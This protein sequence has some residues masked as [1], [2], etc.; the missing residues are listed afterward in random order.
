MNPSNN[1]NSLMTV[2]W[3]LVA[4]VLLVVGGL[5]IAEATPLV[6][7]PAASAEAVQVD[8]LFKIL[9]ALGGSIWLLVQGAV[10]YSVIR[11]R[12]RPGD[13]S[14]GASIHGNST[15]EFVWTLIPSIT[16]VILSIISF[17]VWV[18]ITTAQDNAQVVETRGAR[19][20]WSFSYD[21]PGETQRVNSPVL[22]TWVGQ[23]VVLNLKTADVNHAFWVPSMR[24]KQD[25]LA[26][27][28]TEARFTPILAGEYPVVCA[29]LCG[30][31][32]G[33]MHSSIVVHEDEAS[34]LDWFDEEAFVILNPPD[35]PAEGGQLL[36]T[37]GGVAGL[38]ACAGCHTLEALGWDAIVAPNLENVADRAATRVP[39]M[40]VERYLL[41]SL[42]FPGEFLVPGYDNLM[43]Q[44][45][46]EDPEEANY[47]PLDEALN[48]VAYLC[49]LTASG[50][51][52]CNVDML[53]DMM[54]NMGMG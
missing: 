9:M 33:D 2:V 32:H 49:T 10:I 1:S 6:L 34:F 45:Q 21:I 23:P 42:F 17:Q 54:T 48:I 20:L 53:P 41:R 43:P 11:F 15:L 31:G 51:S 19:F 28:S 27:R 30:S 47:M 36:M 16:V 24:I 29:E 8:E 40:E 12:A 35:D 25:L 39:G 5:I 52:A 7:P 38:Y 50:E 13:D 18:N 14:D 26:G 3:I 44:H 4:F 46:Y 37:A 22:H